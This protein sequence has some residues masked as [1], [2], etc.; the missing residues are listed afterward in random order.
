LTPANTLFMK[1]STRSLDEM[2]EQIQGYLQT[3]ALDQ[4]VQA[5]VKE[6]K[7]DA[8]IDVVAPHL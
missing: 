5:K 6:V 7:A 1:P 2:K 3:Q 8:K 4:A